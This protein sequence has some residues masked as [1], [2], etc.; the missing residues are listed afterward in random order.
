MMAFYNSVSNR[1]NFVISFTQTPEQ[2]FG[3]FAKGYTRAASNLAEQLL[4]KPRFADY[5]AYPVVF[6]YRHAFEL[7]L[8]GL[9]FKAG[10]ISLPNR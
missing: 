6:L 9:Y 3:A 7:S 2:D 10:L 1:N 4:E 5:E 8:K